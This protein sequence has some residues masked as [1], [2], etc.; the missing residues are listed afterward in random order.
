MLKKPFRKKP[1]VFQSKPKNRLAKRRTI[2]DVKLK[3]QSWINFEYN[4]RDIEISNTTN[5]NN[6]GLSNIGL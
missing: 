2:I 5:M 4:E 3:S 1:L 6:I